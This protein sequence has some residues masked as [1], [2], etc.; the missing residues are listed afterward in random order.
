MKTTK[1]TSTKPTKT[2]SSYTQAE[3]DAGADGIWLCGRSEDPSVINS[4]FICGGTC[5]SRRK[6]RG[7]SS[8]YKIFPFII[9]K[10]RFYYILSLFGET[11]AN[12]DCVKILKSLIRKSLSRS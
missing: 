6:R 2:P 7:N 12:F 4:T 8:F 9:N 3:L 10:T 5:P 1:F 11:L